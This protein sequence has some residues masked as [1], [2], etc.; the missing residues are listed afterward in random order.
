M[1][2][3]VQR[4]EDQARTDLLAL[5]ELFVVKGKGDSSFF[6]GWPYDLSPDSCPF[7]GGNSFRVPNL[8]S[9]TYI[10]CILEGGIPHII[11]LIYTFATLAASR[12]DPKTLQGLLGHAK[13]DITMNRY[14]HVRQESLAQAGQKLSGMY[15]V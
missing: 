9:H 1:A 8:F 13:C 7:C 4:R 6:Y 15:D 3:R 14:A 10:D 12:T 11:T 2:Q 5:D